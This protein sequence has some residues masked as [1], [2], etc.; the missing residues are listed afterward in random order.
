MNTSMEFDNCDDEEIGSDNIFKRAIEEAIVS[1]RAI[2]IGEY[3][4]FMTSIGALVPGFV[5]KSLPKLSFNSLI[6][7]VKATAQ[8]IDF[9]KAHPSLPCRLTLRRPCMR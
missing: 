3:N 6:D 4:A 9:I 7:S 2:S 5:I 8:A 1:Q